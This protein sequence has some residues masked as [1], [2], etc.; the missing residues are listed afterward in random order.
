MYRDPYRERRLMGRPR[1]YAVMRQ[2]HRRQYP[3]RSL[4]PYESEA[5]SLRSQGNPYHR[6]YPDGHMAPHPGR[7]HHH[8]RRGQMPTGRRGRSRMM[9]MSGDDVD[10][11]GGEGEEE[12]GGMEAEEEGMGGQFFDEFLEVFNDEQ[13]TPPDFGR[14]PEP[15]PN[16]PI[17][18]ARGVEERELLS[19]LVWRGDPRSRAERRRWNPDRGYLL[20]PGYQGGPPPNGVSAIDLIDINVHGLT[21]MQSMNDQEMESALQTSRSALPE[22]VAVRLA[23]RFELAQDR[24]LQSDQQTFGGK[25]PMMLPSYV[26]EKLSAAPR[27]VG[28]AFDQQT[29]TNDSERA[30]DFYRSNPHHLDELLQSASKAD[31]NERSQYGDHVRD[32]IA[33]IEMRLN[34]P[35]NPRPVS[36]SISRDPLHPLNIPVLSRAK[37]LTRTTTT[38]TSSS[39][40]DDFSDG[41]GVDVEEEEEEATTKYRHESSKQPAYYRRGNAEFLA[42]HLNMHSARS[43][44]SA[45]EDAVRFFK[46]QFGLDFSRES[47]AT[48]DPKTRMRKHATLP[49]VLEPYTVSGSG[50]DSR[51]QMIEGHLGSSSARQHD[52][53]DAI[54]NGYERFGAE[55]G[56]DA[57]SVLEAG[58][59]VRPTSEDGLE[60]RRQNGGQSSAGS[61][62]SSSSRS[63]L[64]RGGILNTGIWV[65]HRPDAAPALLRF[66]SSRTPMVSLKKIPGAGGDG[67]RHTSTNFYNVSDMAHDANARPLKGIGSAL[68]V[69]SIDHSKRKR[70]RAQTWVTL[71]S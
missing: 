32:L 3:G 34:D 24:A 71:H 2:Q 4:P 64:S 67:F 28:R 50:I 7:Y 35:S 33:R 26:A 27:Y 38:T 66:Q 1:T 70:V 11:F 61:S 57:T 9:L 21:D 16:N 10:D 62:S 6:N 39:I 49:A 42:S 69:V 54:G 37:W 12:E 51:L 60:L 5:Y 18:Q 45:E 23:Q 56:S 47:G 20:N 44:L 31:A 17:D 22:E 59:M 55:S 36:A 68:S 53:G 52:G 13:T 41:G 14:G 15:R 43:R 65:L 63:R 19:D 29:R 25:N 40:G 30:I 48:I 58:W 46:N 8:L